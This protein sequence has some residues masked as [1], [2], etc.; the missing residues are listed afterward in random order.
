[1]CQSEKQTP[2]PLV[3]AAVPQKEAT[4]D[5]AA[6]RFAIPPLLLIALIPLAPPYFFLNR[7]YTQWWHWCMLFSFLTGE[8]EFWRNF[9]L[10]QGSGVNFGWYATIVNDFVVHGRLN[11]LL[12]NNMPPPMR[13]NFLVNG[14]LASGGFLS[15]SPLA[16]AMILGSHVIDFLAHPLALYI[17]WKRF[18]CKGGNLKSLVSS[19][20]AIWCTML[21]SRFWSV[22]HQYYNEGKVSGMFYYGHDVYN[23][24]T[25]ES[26]TVAYIC[27][28]AVYV[29]LALYKLYSN[30]S[31]SQNR[32]SDSSEKTKMEPQRP[33]LIQSESSFSAAS[34]CSAT[35]TDE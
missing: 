12:Y 9:V 20:D 14:R 3:I 13:A 29:T 7:G 24:D 28:N 32:R 33:K 2:A 35:M 18:S 8:P 23:V 1:M 16:I 22:V 26:Y 30:H 10:I 15:D 34:T 4:S 5:K 11:H 6:S 31:N 25:V 17:C 19:W 21:L 27:E